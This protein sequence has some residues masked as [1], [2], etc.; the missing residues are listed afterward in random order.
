MFTRKRV[1]ASVLLPRFAIKLSVDER[2]LILFGKLLNSENSILRA[3]TAYLRFAIKCQHWQLNMEL[4]TNV[5]PQNSYVL[6]LFQSIGVGDVTSRSCVSGDNGP[7]TNR[8]VD[9]RFSIATT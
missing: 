5:L 1:A 3:S 2:Q 6:S 8:C 4:I 7:S 9:M